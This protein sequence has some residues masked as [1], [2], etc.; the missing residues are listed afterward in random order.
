MNELPEI[1]TPAFG[2]HRDPF[3]FSDH[4][5]IDPHAPLDWL[6]YTLP[7]VINADRKD[8]LLF[9][10]LRELFAKDV[11][12][13]RRRQLMKSMT[14]Q[15]R[16]LH[17]TACDACVYIHRELIGT[18]VWDRYLLL[19]H[20]RCDLPYHEILTKALATM[21]RRELGVI[22]GDHAIPAAVRVEIE[23]HRDD[24]VF[25]GCISPTRA[26]SSLDEF[27]QYV[28]PSSIGTCTAM[29]ALLQEI[30]NGRL[31]GMEAS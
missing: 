13:E 28:G 14:T 3:D 25:A 27:A 4:V 18:P 24:L 1:P 31:F 21:L 5:R 20:G 2:L 6:K 15:Q 19:L 16:Q 10:L 26:E 29:W 30:E 11:E 17:P 8:G 9:D 23:R 7:G 22:A 12:R